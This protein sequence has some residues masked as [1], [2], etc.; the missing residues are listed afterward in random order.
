M[1]TIHRDLSAIKDRAFTRDEL[2][3]ALGIPSRDL[4]PDT[5]AKRR[6]FEDALDKLVELGVVDARIV[7]E[8]RYYA[9]GSRPLSDYV[10][11]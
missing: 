4:T 9:L 2:M 1:T 6:L 5:A 10:K 3:R 8:R 7:R 11:P